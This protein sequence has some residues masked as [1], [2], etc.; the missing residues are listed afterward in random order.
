M[1]N[2]DDVRISEV[3]KNDD[4]GLILDADGGLKGIWIPVEHRDKPIPDRIATLCTVMYG[5]DVT[6]DNEEESRPADAILH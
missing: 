1:D 3:F 2:N 5:V 4:Y 6:D